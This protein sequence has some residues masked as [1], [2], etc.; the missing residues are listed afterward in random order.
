MAIDKVTA[1]ITRDPGDDTSRRELL[2]FDHS[3]P[4]AG[5]QLPAG[6]VEPG[7]NPADAVLREAREETGLEGLILVSDPVR[8]PSELADGEWYLDLNAGGRAVLER[9]D[10]GHPIV[11]I[12]QTDRERV[13]LSGERSDGTPLRWWDD[14]AIVTRDVRRWLCRLRAPND[15]ANEWEHA[16]DTPEPWR[17]RWVSLSGPP[18]ALVPRQ[19]AWLEAMHPE[20]TSD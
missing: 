13:L 2:V 15:S 4:L 7:E 12:E 17:F 10:L 9:R 18:P 6:T 19:A 16:F 3:N 14:R 8:G 11:R 5:T 1:F 20:L